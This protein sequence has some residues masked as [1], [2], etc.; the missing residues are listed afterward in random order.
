MREREGKRE[1]MREKER[2][3]KRETD[4]QKKRWGGRVIILSENCEENY[5]NDAMGTF[6]TNFVADN[7]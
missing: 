1:R 5:E 4:R 2:E 3:G 7:E 6:S